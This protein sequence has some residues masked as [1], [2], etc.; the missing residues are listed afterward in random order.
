MAGPVVTFRE[1]TS[2][3]A[4]LTRAQHTLYMGAGYGH[5]PERQDLWGHQDLQKPSDY[6]LTLQGNPF[7]P[8]AICPISLT[9]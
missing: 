7:L 2:E 6:R 1:M 9:K 3:P 4:L 5:E 8:G